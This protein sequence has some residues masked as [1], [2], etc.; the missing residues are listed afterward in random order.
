MGHLTDRFREMTER[1]RESQRREQDALM[2]VSHE[3]RT[4][5]TAIRGHV[6]AP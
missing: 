2:V 6:D 4:P 5:V 1:L 3:L